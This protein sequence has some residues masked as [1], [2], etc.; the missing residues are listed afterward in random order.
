MTIGEIIKQKA[1]ALPPDRQ[2]EVLDFVEFIGQKIGSTAASKD[3]L[4]LE[5]VKQ[6]LAAGA[7]MWQDRTDLPQD[8]AQA[9][10]LL[11]DRA[12]DR[13]GS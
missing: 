13:S 7:G 4:S 11:R 12:M 2:R 5:S 10:Q 6:A 8:S 1:D 9:A 3:D